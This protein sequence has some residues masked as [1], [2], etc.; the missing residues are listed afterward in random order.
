MFLNNDGTNST[1][2]ERGGSQKSPLFSSDSFSRAW[3][4][5]PDIWSCVPWFIFGDPLAPER[6]YIDLEPLIRPEGDPLVARERLPHLQGRVFIPIDLARDLL[7]IKSRGEVDIGRLRHLCKNERGDG[8]VYRGFFLPP[9]YACIIERDAH[10]GFRDGSDDGNAVGGPSIEI[11]L[12]G[13]GVRA[14]DGFDLLP[15]FE[16]YIA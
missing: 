12:D 6:P 2:R 5:C 15:V 1:K 13:R 16:E 3:F 14:E 7:R 11:S 10:E 8:V 4:A 9:A